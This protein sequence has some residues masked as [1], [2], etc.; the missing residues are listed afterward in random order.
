MQMQLDIAGAES[1]TFTNQETGEVVRWCAVYASQ[2]FEQGKGVGVKT[3]RLKAD[4]SVYDALK[5][6]KLPA[7]VNCEVSMRATQNGHAL[8]VQRV[9]Q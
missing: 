8:K 7:K 1:G 9:V 3:E 6:A 4:A 5:T 2:P